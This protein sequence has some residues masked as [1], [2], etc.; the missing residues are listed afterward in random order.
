MLCDIAESFFLYVKC[1]SVMVI[2]SGD[3]TDIA[4]VFAGLEM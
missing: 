4:W 2:R 3:V 1:C